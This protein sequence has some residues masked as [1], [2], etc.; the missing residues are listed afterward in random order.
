MRLLLYCLTGFWI[1]LTISQFYTYY[2]KGQETFK[3]Y[4]KEEEKFLA[5]PLSF[6]SNLFF[7]IALI[8][9]IIFDYFVPLYERVPTIFALCP[10][11]AALSILAGIYYFVKYEMFIRKHK[12]T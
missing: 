9:G 7:S 10:I 4:I 11:G 8:L 2:G 3:E 5:L 12:K 6:K 1:Y